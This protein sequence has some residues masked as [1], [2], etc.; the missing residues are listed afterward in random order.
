M[1]HIAKESRSVV[2]GCCQPFRK[3]DIPDSYEFKDKYLA[4][5]K[6]WINPGGSV[7]VDPDG[8]LLAGPAME[9]ETIL[10]AEIQ[11]EMLIGPR[12]QLDVAGNYSRPDVFEL[13]MRKSP[14]P[15]F[16]IIEDDTLSTDSLDAVIPI[17]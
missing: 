17:P 11:P 5:I 7:I 2:I 16:R 8:K 13:H 3:A 10:Y 1:R 12:W 15:G 4:D 9:E 14:M 6:D